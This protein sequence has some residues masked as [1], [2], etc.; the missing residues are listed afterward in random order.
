MFMSILTADCIED[1]GE[2]IC[3]LS[4]VADANMGE[5]HPA[6]HV[7]N[8]TKA[9]AKLIFALSHRALEGAH[10]LASS[11]I[12]WPIGSAL[13]R[14]DEVCFPVGAIAHHH[15]H[16]GTGFRHLVRGSLRIETHDH[17]QIINRGDSWFEP[18]DTPVRAVALHDIGVTSFVRA[19]IVPVAYDAQ[20]TFKLVDPAD[21]ALPRLQVTH[22]HID[23]PIQ[24]DAG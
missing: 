3:A 14:V 4:W 6:G 20:S 8:G 22:R 18:A 2:I 7:K 19:M 15:T 24:V 13:F 11:A 5:S 21:A 9:E 16:C 23:H 1:Q 10:V 12:D 17:H